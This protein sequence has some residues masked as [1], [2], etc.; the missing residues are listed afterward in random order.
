MC[1]HRIDNY[2]KNT[3]LYYFLSHDLSNVTVHPSFSNS[4]EKKTSL[5]IVFIN[6][7][8]KLYPVNV[9]GSVSGQSR[10]I[11]TPPDSIILEWFSVK[12]RPK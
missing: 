7:D 4:N 1:V 8:F 10:K 6:G 2:T 5:T 12:I 11:S 9:C 3:I